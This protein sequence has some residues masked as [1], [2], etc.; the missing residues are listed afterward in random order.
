[1]SQILDALVGLYEHGRKTLT[2]AE[3]E[4][5]AA[6]T[7]RAGDEARR[8]AKVC[9]GL[10]CLVGYDGTSKAGAGNFQDAA[11]VAT[12]LFNLSHQAEVIAALA[13]IGIGATDELNRRKVAA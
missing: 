6:L 1:M 12:L 8:M 4:P 3:L 10:G 9:E 5:L 7:E 11:D 2:D 13:H